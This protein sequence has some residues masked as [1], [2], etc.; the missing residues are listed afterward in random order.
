MKKNHITIFTS[1]SDS[2]YEVKRLVEES[3]KLD[4]NINCI[5][6]KSINDSYDVINQIGDIVMWRNSGID[7]FYGKTAFLATLEGKKIINESIISS[8]FVTHKYYQQTIIK[9]Y[10]PK[11]A[12]DTYVFSN[13]QEVKNYLNNDI[14]KF[15]FIM[16]PNLGSK[17]NGVSLIKD[18]NDLSKILDTKNFVFQNFIENKGDYRVFVVG[19]VCLGAIKRS[20]SDG[21]FLNNVSKGGTATNVLDEQILDAL[22]NIATP[23]VSVFNLDMCGVDIIYDENKKEYK[24]LEVNT[25][26]QFLGFEKATNFNVAR[27]IILYA[28]G[29]LDRKDKAVKYLVKE[30]YDRLLPHMNKT[31]SHYLSRMYL[32]TKDVTYKKLIDENKNDYLGADPNVTLVKKM[33]DE[34]TEF[35]GK[36]AT[37]RESV[38]KKYPKIRVYNDVFFFWL[39]SGA[40]YNIDLHSDLERLI[41]KKSIK[42]TFDKLIKD[43]ESLSVLST[44]A[45]NF[46]YH[47]NNFFGKEFDFNPK[48][49]LDIVNEKKTINSPSEISLS[50]YL[51][52]HCI[53]GA[54]YFYTREIV[55]YKNIYQDMIK[56]LERLILD[57]YFNV[58]LDEKNEFLVC[59][60]LVGLDSGLEK[61]IISETEKSLSSLN[62]FVYDKLNSRNVLEKNNPSSK[63]HTNVLY[64]MTQFPRF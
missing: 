15:P 28:K 11:Y 60:R 19:G 38:F 45:I 64:L 55:E 51:L 57:H 23:I 48:I 36:W 52:T 50:I 40:I 24:F 10:L 14:L 63:E 3:K 1:E 5:D 30:S 26:P 54:S 53:I 31:R 33:N 25:V 34:G 8:P 37:E 41:D 49:F 20:S 58:S 56:T 17:G 46:I 16:K 62:N 18:E 4:I 43:K 22:K 61:I 59:C 13:I 47:A 7:K 21:S 44:H 35:T 42:K 9:K 39:F 27:E 6:F 2:N 12:I 32:W 29:F